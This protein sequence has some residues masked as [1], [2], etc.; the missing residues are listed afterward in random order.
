METR[1]SQL[2]Q[3]DNS[4]LM[5]RVKMSRR[6][7]QSQKEN[8]ERAINTRRNINQLPVLECSSLDLSMARTNMSIVQENVQSAAK[9]A[10]L[11]AAEEKMKQLERWKERK[12]LQKEKRERERRD[13]FKT[14]LYRPK[15]TLMFVSLPPVPPGFKESMRTTRSMKQQ[16]KCP[17]PVKTQRH[18]AANKV[19]RT[20]RSRAAAA[21]ANPA[22]APLLTS[23]RVCAVDPTIRTLS[24]RS[25]NRPP[26][27]AVPSVKDNP[28]NKSADLRSARTKANITANAPYSDRKRNCSASVNKPS[29]PKESKQNPCPSSPTP[30]TMAADPVPAGDK[31]SSAL[32]SFAP[33][34][35]TFEAPKGLSS[36]RFEP[37]T[38][39]SADAFLMPSCSFSFPPAPV[40]SFD[41]PAGSSQA[42]STKARPCPSSMLTDKIPVTPQGLKRDV[43]YFRSEIA[44]E[45][46]RLMSLCGCWEPKVEDESI[47]EEMRDQMRTAV[48]QARLLMKE[49]FKQFSGLV[50]DCEFRRGDKITTCT[51][52]Q[53]FWDMVYYQVEDINRKFD[54][55]KEAE[56]RGW[57][58]EEKPRPQQKKV[59]KKQ[60]A[61]VKSAGTKA[62]AKSRLAAAKA[63]MKARQQG[64]EAEK[65]ADAESDLRVSCEE[66]GQI[67]TVVVHG[68]SPTKAPGSV[69]RSSRLNGV[70]QPRPSPCGVY[71]TPR[72]T[73]QSTALSRTPVHTPLPASPAQLSKSIQ[74]EVPSP[75]V[76]QDPVDTP[77][78]TGATP[79]N[80]VIEDIPGLD[81][82]LY[83]QP[84]Q[85]CSLSPRERVDSKTLSPMT[86]DVEFKSPVSRSEDVP[87]Q[88]V[89]A[90]S[91]TPADLPRQ[92]LQAHTAESTMLLFTPNLNDRIR[93]SVCPSDLMV[94]TPPSAV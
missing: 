81:F 52:L 64:T 59:I 60:P 34:G 22:P 68:D 4:V 46:E 92:S 6:R 35:F 19:E 25:A 7:S 53:G 83:L 20:T 49:R 26:V 14:G 12:A 54:A 58:E 27:V 66:A 93:Q 8:R 71:H 37:L 31:P 50:D 28:K 61:V 5:L 17:Q 3:R 45:T 94:F 89:P 75:L 51:D 11:K 82:E 57:V 74:E 80:S 13:V 87:T 18:T 33:E 84:S 24:I 38:P 69:R 63:A 1:F 15:D 48:G 79:D 23:T 42:S 72:V 65:A 76:V 88:H 70:A 40:L 29:A 36:F 2:R 21:A 73:R 85:Q 44:N 78:P 77:E 62:A 47:T 9:I 32:S 41:H 30:C 16:Q 56:A 10:K 39:R 90:L 55:L 86:V 43:P 91:L 67:N